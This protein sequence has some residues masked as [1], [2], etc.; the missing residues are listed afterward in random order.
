MD[1][2]VYPMAIRDHHG[3]AGFDHRQDAIFEDVLP[4]VPGTFWHVVHFPMGVFGFVKQVLGVGKRG[5][6]PPILQLCVPA[7]MVHMQMRAHDEVDRFRRDAH[8]SHIFEEGTILHMPW[9]GVRAMLVIADASVDQ[10]SM[11]SRLDDVAVQAHQQTSA[12][13]ID[14]MRVEP[15]L[16]F[17]LEGI[18]VAIW[19]D[20]AG[21]EAGPFGFDT[22]LYRRLAKP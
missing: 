6:P 3:L 4:G 22:A 9:H 2:I 10:D 11:P 13:R 16:A 20:K 12:F 7:H 8:A 21:I 15:I 14:E 1:C 17:G 18:R 19:K 5:D